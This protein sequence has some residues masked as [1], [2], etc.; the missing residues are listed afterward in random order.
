MT[1]NCLLASEWLVSLSL[2]EKKVTKFCNLWGKRGLQHTPQ[3]FV[4]VAVTPTVPL[5]EFQALFPRQ[6]ICLCQRFCILTLHLWF[7]QRISAWESRKMPNH[8]VFTSTCSTTENCRHNPSFLMEKWLMWPSDE[9]GD[10]VTQ[11]SPQDGWDT[12]TQRWVVQLG[13]QKKK[14]KWMDELMFIRLKITVLLRAVAPPE[15]VGWWEWC[16][17]ALVREDGWNGRKGPAAPRPRG[18]DRSGFET[19][20]NCKEKQRM[21]GDVSA[22]LL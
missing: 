4:C 6:A 8:N 16:K 2:S 10:L 13:W 11:A 20:L 17:G 3:S 19:W 22:A 5:V 7:R 1:P 9:L 14:K 18:S 12:H 21:Q 15:R